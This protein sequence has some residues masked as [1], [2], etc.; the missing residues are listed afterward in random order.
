[1]RERGKITHIN[2]NIAIIFVESKEE[3]HTCP[4]KKFCSPSSGGMELKSINEIGAKIGDEVEIETSLKRTNWVIFFLF[5]VP[6]IML[7]L[8]IVLG[9]NLMGTDSFGIFMGFILMGLYFAGLSVIDRHL[10]QKGKIIPRITKIIK[11]K[12]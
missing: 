8:G 5:I 1:M 4:M 10:V 7:L 9:K 6:V 2:E 12:T 3:C 11:E